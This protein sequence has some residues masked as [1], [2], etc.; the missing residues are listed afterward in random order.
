MDWLLD[1]LGLNKGK[2]T[3]NAAEQNQALLS[4]LESKI[5]GLID[6]TDA[7]QRGYLN[8]A[9]GLVD[10]GDGGAGILRDVL[11]LGGD[12]GKARAMAAFRDSN[13]AYDFQMEQGLDALDRR[14]ASRGML[15]SGN[16]NLDTLRFSQG[17]AD[18][19]FGDWFDRL[20]GGIDRQSGALGDLTTQAGASGASR[21]AL[22]GDIGSGRMAANNQYAAGREAGQGGFW[23]ILDGVASAAGAFMGMGGGFGGGRGG[24]PQ[25]DMS[26]NMR[27]GYGGG[28]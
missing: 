16:T 18:Q 23:D 21:I 6:T 26:P 22:A 10:L 19:S 17:L 2:A 28:F 27:L 5:G 1:F 4:G 14:A 12:E 13:P 20:M 8:E 3:M 11:G 25:T 15:G 7:T 9:L 24:V